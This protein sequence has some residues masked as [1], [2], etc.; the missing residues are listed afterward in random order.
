MSRP[1]PQT[2]LP[3]APT[4]IYTFAAGAT[5]N[6]TPVTSITGSATTV[7]EPESLTLDALNNIYY[8]DFEGGT[9]TMMKFPAGTTGNVAPATSVTSTGYTGPDWV[10]EIAVF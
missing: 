1:R 8:V 9:L 7:N 4:A 2:T 6:P 10:A 5:G 3:A